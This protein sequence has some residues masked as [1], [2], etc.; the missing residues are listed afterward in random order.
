M[1]NNDNDNNYKF[2]KFSYPTLGNRIINYLVAICSNLIALR[3]LFFIFLILGIISDRVLYKAIGF[4]YGFL[5]YI[6]IF[7]VV[8]LLLDLIYIFS[9]KGIY[10]YEDNRVV[11]K[12]GFF[13]LSNYYIFSR[14]KYNFY[15]Y[16]IKSIYVYNDKKG[17]TAWESPMY[18]SKHNS[19]VIIEFIDYNRIAIP[20]EDNLGFVNEIFERKNS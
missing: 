19:Y 1:N 18:L 8:L 10:L 6:L 4:R 20:L 17:I 2:Y 13:A 5:T 7:I 9:K 15:T 16:Q 14:F 3:Y 11:I 12:F